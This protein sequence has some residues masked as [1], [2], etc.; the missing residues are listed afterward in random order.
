[1]PVARGVVYSR[2]EPDADPTSG[3]LVLT[4]DT[5]NSHMS[6]FTVVPI[7]PPHLVAPPHSPTVSV[8]GAARAVVGQVTSV[9]EDD[10]GRPIAR[11]SAAD[12][13]AVED[14]LVELLGIRQLCG[15]PPRSLPAVAGAGYP[16][17]SHIYYGPRRARQTKR[18]VVVSNN[19]WNKLTRGAVVLRTTSNV[20][21]YGPGFPSIQG[22][23]AVACAGD[24]VSVRTTSLDLR[25]RPAPP[26]LSLAEMTAIGY[27]VL[28]IHDIQM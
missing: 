18:W 27:A 28:D 16:V 11:L 9:T 15:S 25:Q 1:V 22:G 17:W 5:W 20:R 7:A 14:A 2:L 8:L 10:L 12:L 4:N 26:S 13:H 6:D 3:L 24:I 19:E 21:R 23:R